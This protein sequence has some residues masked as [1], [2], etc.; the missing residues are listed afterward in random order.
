MGTTSTQTVSFPEEK[1]GTA[2]STSSQRPL[3]EPKSKN[4]R[5]SITM[6][7]SVPM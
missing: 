1:S 6:V 4:P 5:F 3:P 2:T 7:G